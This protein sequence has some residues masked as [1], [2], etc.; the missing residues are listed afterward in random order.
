MSLT[1]DISNWCDSKFKICADLAQNYLGLLLKHTPSSYSPLFPPGTK[2]SL[3]T[4]LSFCFGLLYPRSRN[5]HFPLLNLAHPFTIQS[6]LSLEWP[7]LS[8][9]MQSF[10]SCHTWTWRSRCTQYYH[11]GQLLGCWAVLVPV[12]LLKSSAYKWQ[13]IWAIDYCKP[14]RQFSILLM[15][16]NIMGSWPGYNGKLHQTSC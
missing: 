4:D 16:L 13:I 12:F 8:E 9:Y 5:S 3:Q 10:L 2:G 11:L 7:F 1:M 14:V 15:A 6:H